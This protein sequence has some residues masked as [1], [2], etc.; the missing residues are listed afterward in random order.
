MESAEMTP[1]ERAVAALECRCPDDIVPTFELV[2]YLGQEKFG[3]DWR[4]DTTKLSAEEQDRFLHQDAE[5]HVMIAEAYDYSIIRADLGEIRILKEWGLD[6]KYLLC[7]E[8]D[9][10]MS[11]PNGHDMVDVAVALRE[12]PEEMHAQ[13]KRGAE[14]AK[15]RGEEFR[16]AGAEAVTMCADYC[17]NDGPF[18]SPDMFREFVTPYLSEIIASHRANGL[19]TIKHTDGDIMPIL[20]QLLEANPHALHSIDPQAGVDLAEVKRLATGKTCLCGN[21]NCGLLQTGTDEEV[22]KD[23]LRSLRDGMPGGGYIFATSNCAF[24]GL[25]LERYEMMMEIRKEF[26]R[27]DRQAH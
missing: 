25:P 4:G 3:R 15:R 16:E 21:V 17:F 7:G 20:D 8:A 27:Y 1:K 5:L 10:T 26:G 24:R 19:Y 13:F 18:L 2:Y 23:V 9:G 6:K 14:S 22:R 11:I 12:R